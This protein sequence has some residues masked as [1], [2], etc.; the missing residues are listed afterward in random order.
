MVFDWLQFSVVLF[1]VASAVAI[2]MGLLIPRFFLAPKTRGGA[3]DDP[4]ECGMKPLGGAWA[5][6]GVTFYLYTLLF[7]AFD[8]DVLYLF[9]AAVAYRDSTGWLP[10]VEV[11]IFV[12]VLALAGLYFYRK[13]VF[14]W[15][16]K[17]KF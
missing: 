15:P 6:V 5:R 11:F 4:Y 8:V 12:A 3:Y 17:I 9:P 2:G 10:F 7:L 13:G 14:E 16:R 1:L